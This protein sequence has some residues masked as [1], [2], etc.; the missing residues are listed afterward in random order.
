MCGLKTYWYDLATNSK[1]PLVRS[2]TSPSTS[3]SPSVSQQGN[4]PLIYKLGNTIPVLCKWKLQS[5]SKTIMDDF[6]MSIITTKLTVFLGISC[7]L[8]L[9]LLGHGWRKGHWFMAWLPSKRF[10]TD[11]NSVHLEKNMFFFSFARSNYLSTEKLY[12]LLSLY[13]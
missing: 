2:T 1:E 11:R 7:G 4:L 10:C 12:G 3:C 9:Q 8:T 13:I 5:T 6:N